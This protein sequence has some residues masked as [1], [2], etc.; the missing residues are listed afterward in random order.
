MS[1]TNSPVVAEGW[2]PSC[3]SGGLPSRRPRTRVPVC[4]TRIWTSSSCSCPLDTHNSTTS[5]TPHTAEPTDPLTPVCLNATSSCLSLAVLPDGRDL[6]TWWRLGLRST[7]TVMWS[8]LWVLW[9]HG[10]VWTRSSAKAEQFTTFHPSPQTNCCSIHGRLTWQH[11]P[12]VTT[13]SSRNLRTV[14]R[15]YT[16]LYVKD[17]ARVIC[18]DAVCTRNVS[19]G[20]NWLHFQGS[21]GLGTS[22][23]R[24]PTPSVSCYHRIIGG[25]K[26]IFP[27]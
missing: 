21:G 9:W 6:L 19:E 23:T 10:G 3:R 27:I 8:G 26:Q 15:C 22:D 2:A 20:H 25:K 24:A 11:V 16:V 7:I 1:W 17:S 18:C 13:R 12:A 5:V 14:R 4:E